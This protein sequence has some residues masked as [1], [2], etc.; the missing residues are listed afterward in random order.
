MFNLLKGEVYK[1]WRSKSLYI[2][3][4]VMLVFVFLLYGMFSL[5]DMM[6]QGEV[7]N[8][9][10][11]LTVNEGVTSV[12]D[13]MG[14]PAIVQMMFSSISALIVAIFASIYVF[15][16]YANGAIKNVV[17]K[18]YGRGE[19]FLSKFVG[20]VVGTIVMQV[21]MILGVLV[22]EAI[23]LGG[24]RINTDVF[25]EIAGYTAMQLLLSTALTAIIV[26]I[27]Q[28]CR[29]L[30]AGIAISACMIMFSSFATTGINALLKYMDINVNVCD[31][32]VLDLISNCP[33]GNMDNS[34]LVRAIVCA[35]VWIV[36]AIGI[37][38]IHFRKADVK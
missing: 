26:T 36:V 23:I 38:G 6:Q 2:C 12:W 5:A 7:A 11:G 35:I 10:Y 9:S 32:W 30:G 20:T 13:E 14:I 17:G 4:A 34:F 1:L 24:S 3:S 37:G 21:V 22:C 19:V 33:I 16:D 25:A 8:G 28:I 29:N 15:G 31:Y 27:S 18:G